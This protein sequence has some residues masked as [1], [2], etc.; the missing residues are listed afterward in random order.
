MARRVTPLALEAYRRWQNL[1]PEQKQR[2]TKMAREYA[3]R[4]R[5]AFDQAQ[6]R[7]GGRR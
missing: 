4:G 7:R 5:H 2:Y 6:R 1:T 3:G